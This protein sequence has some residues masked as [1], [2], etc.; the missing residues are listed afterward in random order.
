MLVE[1]IMAWDAGRFVS[2]YVVGMIVWMGSLVYLGSPELDLDACSGR[3]EALNILSDSLDAAELQ[4]L[5]RRCEL[6]L[7][8]TFSPVCSVEQCER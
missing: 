8:L 6:T 7:L 3:R 4:L 1:W 5:S 2:A